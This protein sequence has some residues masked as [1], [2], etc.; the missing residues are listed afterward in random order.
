VWGDEFAAADGV[1]TGSGWTVFGWSRGYV[2]F[3]TRI[4]VKT[5]SA[6]TEFTSTAYS[7]DGL[8]WRLGGTFNLAQ[9]TGDAYD[10]RVEGVVESAAGLL[11]VGV[12]ATECSFGSFEWPEA[13]SADGV[14]WQP[15]AQTNAGKVD[16]YTIQQ[17]EGGAAGFIAT[18]TNGAFT[19]IGGLSWTAIDLKG[20]ATKTLQG[21]QSG[22]SFSGGFI[23]TG[24]AN[25]PVQDSCEQ[26][27]V[28]QNPSLWWSEDGKTWTAQKIPN[29]PASSD[30]AMAVCRYGDHLLMAGERTSAGKNLE[31]ISTDGRSWV[32][33]QVSDPRTCPQYLDSEFLTSGSRNLVLSEDALSAPTAF[34][35][36]DDG[37]LV[38]LTQTGDEPTEWR[39]G[40]VTL[41]GPAG[42]VEVDQEGNTYVGVPVAG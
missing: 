8:V 32:P 34:T 5:G 36:R 35:V 20:P 33:L 3:I 13:F 16:D 1:S 29:A 9:T 42:L 17:I 25:I 24:E 38:Q 11:A 31:W 40:D 21:L 14:T 30:Q 2:A 28:Y 23:L 4:V 18:G 12:S 19:S 15:A 7:T 41:F 27:P 39:D 22:A 37:A 6:N 26:T 10:D